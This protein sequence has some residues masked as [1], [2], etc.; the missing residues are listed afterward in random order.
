MAYDL[1]SGETVPGN[2]A[3]SSTMG[4]DPSI[5]T[6]SA[7]KAEL[8]RILVVVD[9]VNLEMGQAMTDKKA[10]PA[11]WKAW[12][13]FYLTAHKYLTRASSFWGSNVIVARTYEREA[14]KW[15]T[16]LESRGVKSVGPEDQGRRNEPE[17]FFTPLRVGLAIGSVTA[18][19]LL[20]NALKK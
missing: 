2:F 5:W 3:R 19:A 6:P 9:T 14:N 11:E 15:R 7:V 8:G 4:D 13:Q 17:P 18:G 10:T 16:L 20:I 12:Y 1:F